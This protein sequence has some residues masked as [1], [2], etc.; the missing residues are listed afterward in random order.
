M[1]HKQRV[2]I[3]GPISHGD[4]RTN[5]RQGTEAAIN[6]MKLGYAPLCPMLAC[7]MS[8]D[9]PTIDG[10]G[11]DHPTNCGF[12]HK[13]WL[14]CDLPW[15]AVSDLLLRLPGESKGADMEVKHAT[16]LGIPVYHS[17]QE[18]I[19]K[20]PSQGDPRFVEI[21]QQIKALHIKKSADYG[22]DDDLLA[23]VRGA[24]EFGIPAWI[25]VLIRMR[26]KMSRL[27][28]FAKKG[29]LQNESAQDS[30]RDLASYSLI[31]SILLEEETTGGS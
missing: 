16:E 26:D 3:A 28:R 15:V 10:F 8:G 29:A 12:N 27:A 2:Y 9:T 24:E 21:L 11:T 5:I 4:L 31:A 20:P 13:E 25:G 18:I 6:L 14:D 23:N 17:V 7:Y 19:D 30:L 1:S 22:A